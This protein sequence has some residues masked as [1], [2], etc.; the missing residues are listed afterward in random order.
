M[1]GLGVKV[2]STTPTVARVV[3]V[4]IGGGKVGI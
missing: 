3:T 4:T 1:V 2:D